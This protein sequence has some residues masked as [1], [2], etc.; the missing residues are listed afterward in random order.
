MTTI[1]T[2]NPE[3]DSLIRSIKETKKDAATFT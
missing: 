1:V 3:K 2:R